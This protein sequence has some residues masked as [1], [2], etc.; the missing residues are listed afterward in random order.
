MGEIPPVPAVRRRRSAAV[1]KVAVFTIPGSSAT[2]P[3]SSGRWSP[4]ALF[5]SPTASSTSRTGRSSAAMT[6]EPD[7]R[8][9]LVHDESLGRAST[10]PADRGGGLAAD[11][12]CRRPPAFADHHT[13]AFAAIGH[14][15]CTCAA[16]SPARETGSHSSADALRCGETLAGANRNKC[17]AHPVVSSSVLFLVGWFS[18]QTVGGLLRPRRPR[19]RRALH[20]DDRRADGGDDSPRPRS[21]P[22]RVGP[23]RQEAHLHAV[24]GDRRGLARGRGGAR[25][26]PRLRDRRC[27]GSACFGIGLGA[28]NTLI[29]ALQADTVDYGEWKTGNTG[30]GRQLQPPVLFPQDRPGHRRLAGGIHD[31]DRWLRLRRRQPERRALTSIKVAAGAIP[32][33]V[34]LAGTAVMLL[35]PLTEQALRRMV[36]EM[37]A[38]RAERTLGQPRPVSR[39]DDPRR[40]DHRAG[41]LPRR[42]TGLVAAL[43]RPALGRHARRRRALARR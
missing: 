23:V 12:G 27:W 7:E 10:D 13:I 15:A 21:C 30:R 3:R 9:R 20:R 14:R 34:I 11:R 37:A 2:T 28:I 33:V 8:A 22:K 19:Q 17:A 41:R 16:S 25:T 42:G 31:R 1:A 43:G 32:A 29:F 35:Y 4:T 6:Q 24:G 5:S 38:R 40:G 36:A 26:L 18:V 39:A